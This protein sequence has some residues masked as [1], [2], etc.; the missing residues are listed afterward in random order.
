ML[1]RNQPNLDEVRQASERIVND[2]SVP[3]L[4]LYLIRPLKFAP[5]REGHGAKHVRT[6]ERRCQRHRTMAHVGRENRAL[7][8][9]CQIPT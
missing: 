6:T 2:G 1:K 5:I 3:P 9:N 8:I 4:V 7:S